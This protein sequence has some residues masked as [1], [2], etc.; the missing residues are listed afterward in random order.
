MDKIQVDDCVRTNSK[1]ILGNQQSCEVPSLRTRP[2][3]REYAVAERIAEGA[4]PIH[5][6]R[7]PAV[8]YTVPE[9]AWVGMTLRQAI[10]SGID[11]ISAQASFAANGRARAGAQTHGFVRLV[12]DR[13]MG[14][15]AGSYCRWA[16]F[17]S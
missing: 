7:I 17:P 12:A 6:E 13:E 3:T 1:K 5:L 15:S 14:K 9:I 8:I 2:R 4:Y 11:A 10:D 16:G